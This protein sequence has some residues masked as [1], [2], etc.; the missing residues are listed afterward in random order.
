MAAHAK[1]GASSSHR[2][3]ECPGSIRLSQGVSDKGSLFAMEGTAAHE[4]ASQC[5]MEDVDA[6]DYLGTKI[7]VPG[8][9]EPFIVNEDMVEAVQVYLDAVNGD[10]EKGDEI[11]IE[12]KFS[13]ESFYSGMF[14]TSD[15]VL[16]QP[17]SNLLRV[18]DYKHG[19]GVAVDVENNPQ[20]QYYGVGSALSFKGFSEIEL[21]VVQPRATHRDGPV[22]RWRLSIIELMDFMEDL[23][24]AAKRTEAPD[25]ALKSGDHCR[26][27]PARGFCPELRTS[28]ER[29]AMVEFTPQGMNSAPAPN[30]L[31]PED[32]DTILRQADLVETWIAAVREYAHQSMVA[33][34]RVP[35]WK[36]VAKRANRVWTDEMEAAMTLKALGVPEDKIYVKKIVSPAAGEKLVPK[37]IRDQL[38]ELIA[39]G[40]SSGSTLAREE[41]KRPAIIA[42]AEQEFTPV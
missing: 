25:A 36:L 40:T 12:H 16:L 21:V 23:R 8:A 11:Y 41:D 42:G 28:A 19:A 35:G 39:P 26:F 2:W 1:L 3:M 7:E 32:I 34:L 9:P 10:R 6:I 22:R 14:G 17:K 18:Y 20:L 31:S 30:F 4:L 37:K 24:E 13:L 5:L 27:C 38:L 15:A 33:G 29:S